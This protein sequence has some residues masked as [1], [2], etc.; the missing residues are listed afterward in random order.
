MRHLLTILVILATPLLLVA[1]SD[2]S[3]ARTLGEETARGIVYTSET[4]Y[5]L[6]LHTNGYA[7]GVD[8]GKLR[9]YY[10]TRYLT[11]EFGEIRHPKETRMSNDYAGLQGTVSRP[12]RFG[13]QNN[14]FVLRGGVG[15]KRY[16][17]EKA[18]RKGVSVGMSY[19]AGPT[20]GLLKPYYLELYLSPDEQRPQSARYTEE[21]ASIFLDDFLIYGGSGV[22]KGIGETTIRPGG[23]IKAALHLDWGAFDKHVKAVEA[24]FMAD[25]FLQRVPILVE[26]PDLDLLSE[27][28]SFFINFFVNIQ[29]GVRK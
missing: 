4:A 27:N 3:S 18:R 14:L 13:K 20:I 28:R 7:F 23:F 1:Q 29:L 26:R 8:I 9:T 17:T 2:Y 10:S 21:N 15:E 19:S 11:F 5:N 6:R 25:I 12:F 24:G 22:T 16:F